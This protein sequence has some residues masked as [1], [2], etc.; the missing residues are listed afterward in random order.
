MIKSEIITDPHPFWL[1]MFECIF[2][3]THVYVMCV[4]PSVLS[5]VIIIT[6]SAI[7]DSFLI[8]VV[9][10]QLLNLY[11]GLVLALGLF[12][13]IVLLE[14]IGRTFLYVA[15]WLDCHHRN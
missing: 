13:V 1:W 4:T 8:K 12:L 9:V 5:Q 10:T 3:F 15:E 14:F 7:A 2:V 6:N 11:G